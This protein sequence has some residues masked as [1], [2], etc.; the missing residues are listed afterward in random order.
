MINFKSEVSGLGM[1]VLV[2]LLT[3]RLNEN[4]NRLVVG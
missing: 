1:G 4:S 3:A 2:N